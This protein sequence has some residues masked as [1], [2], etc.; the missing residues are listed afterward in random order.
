MGDFHRKLGSGSG[1]LPS[2]TNW[3]V[4]FQLAPTLFTFFATT[5]IRKA[6][7]A[8]SNDEG[9]RRTPTMRATFL[10]CR[11]TRGRKWQLTSFA[12]KKLHTCRGEHEAD[13]ISMGDV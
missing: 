12:A 11:L 13:G 8:L 7:R 10:G 5:S 3:A 1:D 4:S 9:I 6:W 2:A